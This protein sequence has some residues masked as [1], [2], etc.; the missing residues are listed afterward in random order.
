MT[1]LVDPSGVVDTGL[2]S[3]QFA[4]LIVFLPL[5]TGAVFGLG[6]SIWG[7]TKRMDMRNWQATP[8]K[9][10]DVRGTQRRIKGMLGRIIHVLDLEVEYLYAWENNGYK[11]VLT[12][13]AELPKSSTPLP[14]ELIVPAVEKLRAE[15]LDKDMA[16][17]VNPRRPEQSRM[18]QVE[19]KRDAIAVAVFAVLAGVFGALSISLVL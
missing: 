1:P 8:G 19:I 7:L 12:R 14:D 15:V 13:E 9:V 17:Y 10:T 3:S 18:E 4:T 2:L 11:A 6:I 16:V 5:F